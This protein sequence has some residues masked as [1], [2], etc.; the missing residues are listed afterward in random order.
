MERDWFAQHPYLSKLREPPVLAKAIAAALARSDAKYAYADGIDEARG[1]YV[2]LK[3]A[4]LVKH[5]E[6]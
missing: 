3:L 1:E 5:P 6:V 4:Q 2:G